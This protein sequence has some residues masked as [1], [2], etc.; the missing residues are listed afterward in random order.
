MN[1][2]AL[3]GKAVPEGKQ[4]CNQCKQEGYC[5]HIWDFEGF[6]PNSARSFPGFGHIRNARWKCRLC[7]KTRTDD[8]LKRAQY[9]GSVQREM[10]KEEA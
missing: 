4:V 1:C 3:C 5:L 9:W 6:E 10:R 8:T 7:G 2:C